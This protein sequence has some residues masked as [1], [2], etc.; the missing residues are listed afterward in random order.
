[1]FY[2]GTAD[3]YQF[4]G[5]S[6]VT[7]YNDRRPFIIPNSVNETL[8]ATGKPV[9]TEN[10][11]FIDE[12]HMDDYYYHASNKAMAYNNRIIDKSFLKLRDVTLSYKL[13]RGWA[14]K[15]AANN[16]SLTFYGR[17]FI[18]WTP[19]SNLYIDPEATNFGNDLASEIGEFRTGPTLKSFGVMLKANF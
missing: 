8:D 19:Q 13:P 3:L 4:T 5:N 9:Y 10:T 18:L 15:V 7:T 16:L 2:S 17:N 11:T 14:S 6:Y 1:M 12:S